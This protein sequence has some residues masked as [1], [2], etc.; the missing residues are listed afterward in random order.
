VDSGLTQQY[1]YDS[2]SRL[3][4]AALAGGN[5]ASFGYDAVG[6]RT[7][8]GNTSPAS[9]TAYTIA[10][11]SN[12]MSQA[13]T[14]GLTRTFTHN[15]NGDITAFTNSAGIANTLTYDPFGRL[16]SHTRSGVT[17]TYTVN[18][19]DQRMAKSWTAQP[20]VDT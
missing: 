11:T 1:G 13:I 5:T 19:L 10:G 20:F 6:N 2:Q 7:S 3:I 4:S 17:T 8:A 18:A 14:G 15:A 16:A 12:R 9:S